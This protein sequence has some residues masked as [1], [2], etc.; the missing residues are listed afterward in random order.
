MAAEEDDEGPTQKFDLRLAP[1]TLRYL[2]EIK[3]RNVY[4]RTVTAVIRTFID[5]GIREAIDKK[6]IVV[7]VED[8]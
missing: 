8:E 6:Y 1:Q 7:D 5:T 2:R 4:G 3:R